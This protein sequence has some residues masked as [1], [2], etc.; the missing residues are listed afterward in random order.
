MDLYGFMDLYG[1]IWIYG[2][3]WINMDLYEFI[4]IYVDL[5]GFKWFYHRNSHEKY[6]IKDNDD[7]Y[8]SMMNIIWRNIGGKSSANE[9]L[10]LSN[11]PSIYSIYP[12]RACFQIH[13]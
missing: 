1:L 8:C 12:S 13:P 11:F 7:M 3:I 2:F 4:W 6:D 5:Y 9:Q 10:T